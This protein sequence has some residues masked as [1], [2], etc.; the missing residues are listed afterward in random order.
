M[1]QSRAGRPLF[2]N[3][4]L[5][6]CP[7]GAKTHDM[8]SAIY[9]EH[10]R[11][12]TAG[13]RGRAVAATR[14]LSPSRVSAPTSGRKMDL[15]RA[16]GKSNLLDVE[17]DKYVDDELNV[18][19]VRQDTGDSMV[20]G[21]EKELE[22]ANIYDFELNDAHDYALLAELIHSDDDIQGRLDSYFEDEYES[23][24]VVVDA[25]RLASVASGAGQ[26]VETVTG[27]EMQDMF[28]EFNKA[29]KENNYDLTKDEDIS[30]TAEEVAYKLVDDYG[31]YNAG[32]AQSVPEVAGDG[33][34][35]T[36]YVASDYCDGLVPVTI[37][38]TPEDD[39][40]DMS[41][42][43]VAERLAEH[44]WGSSMWPAIMGGSAAYALREYGAEPA[45]GAEIAPRRDEVNRARVEDM[46]RRFVVENVKASYDGF[47]GE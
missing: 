17:M 24:P 27:G 5:G 34:F 20:L 29:A 22:L 13:A 31:F 47:F 14:T 1:G 37:R 4:P 35:T 3:C 25:A 28:A 18:V 45:D 36:M 40:N 33:A 42:K 7:T 23:D 11:M 46:T 32:P 6:K 8:N 21:K 44:A 41:D 30:V 16:T 15:W 39:I 12:A 19:V 43:H 26:S 9:K 38:T 10:L 2:V